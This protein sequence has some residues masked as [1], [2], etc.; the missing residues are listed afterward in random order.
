MVAGLAV[1]VVTTFA[2]IVVSAPV[3][4]S[5]VAP[6]G[7]SKSCRS[8]AFPEPSTQTIDVD[9]VARQYRVATPARGGKGLRPLILN[10][11][12]QGR[13]SVT[14]ATYSELEA[15]GPAR[16]FV[17]IT[18][19][20]GEQNFWTLAVPNA[21]MDSVEIDALSNLAFTSA[22]IETAVADLC[23]NA[24]RV[25]ATG[26]SAGAA[27]SVYLGCTLRPQLAGIAPVAGVNAALPCPDGKP[28]P[29]IAFHGTADPEVSYD[30]RG[31]MCCPSIAP[32]AVEDAVR[33]WAERAGC[34]A[35]PSRKRIGSDVERI[36][37]RGCVRSSDVVLY[38]VVNGAHNWPGSFEL[39]DLGLPTQDINAADLILD[40]FSQ[41][42]PAKHAQ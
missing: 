6:A 3:E 19:D 31:F 13:D 27:M 37:Y 20:V 22:L 29:V 18:P 5:S 41:H 9:G 26:F 33:V 10:F 23:V 15:K 21:T 8:Q 30:A 24:R 12:G 36:A 1:M 32:Q 11:H 25:Y 40:F 7:I 2:A 34:Q 39:D 4:A 35:K 28:M 38:K 17:V 42:P 16:G 14:Q